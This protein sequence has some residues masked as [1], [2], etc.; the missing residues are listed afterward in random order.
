MKGD[1]NN[2]AHVAL[3]DVVKAFAM[4]SFL[5]WWCAVWQIF[6]KLNF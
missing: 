3:R 2:A 6:I 4:P 5:A 1:I